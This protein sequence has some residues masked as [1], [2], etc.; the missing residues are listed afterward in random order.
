MSMILFFLL[1]ASM[2]SSQRVIVNSQGERIIMYPDGSWRMAEPGD[3][4]LIRQYAQSSG[5]SNP[6]SISS[7]NPAQRNEGEEQEYL[8]RQWNELY[9]SIRAEDK[10]VQNDF[11]TTTTAQIKA[12]ERLRNAEA[13]KKLIEPD[14]LA[15]LKDDYDLSVSN[16]KSAKLHQKEINKLV[17]KSNKVNDHIAKLNS[18]KLNQVKSDFNL[19]LTIYDP[20]RQVNIVP[21]TSKTS[22]VDPNPTPKNPK[23][24]AQPPLAVNESMPYD[25]KMIGKLPPHRKPP[26][27]FSKPFE[28]IFKTD[29]INPATGR[30]KLVLEP[31]PIFTHTDPDLRPYFKDKDLITCRGQLS[32][33]GPYVYLSLDFQIA[34]SHSQS[35]FGSLE[36]GSL[37]R[38]KLFDGEY[39]SIYN[40]KSD[41]G[42]IDPYSGNTIF[43]AQYALGKQEIKKLSSS[44]LDKMRVLWGTGYED[45]EVH[46]IDFLKNQL[47][48]LMSKK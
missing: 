46:H 14:Q 41:K 29:T 7:N 31:S 26:S 10:K 36:T 48:C 6:N 24:Q 44:S 23:S 43:A 32:K 39:V 19:Y 42:R 18:R 12:G 16:L 15:T 40:L 5:A 37:L 21:V 38:L 47:A 11:R 9:T 45:Y 1:L 33:I 25:Q 22:A 34:S 28:C 35:N 4:L 8:L 3:S 13:N 27:Y 20:G 2:S 17:E 30:R